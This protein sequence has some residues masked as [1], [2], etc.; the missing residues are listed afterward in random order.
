VLLRR[1]LPRQLVLYRRPQLLPS[2]P[3]RASASYIARLADA[4]NV[5]PRITISR[6]AIWLLQAPLL[7][8]ELLLPQ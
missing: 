1:Q 8:K 4:L 6:T 7:A 5:D 2:Q 3:Q